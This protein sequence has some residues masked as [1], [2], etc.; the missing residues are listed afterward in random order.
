MTRF[1]AL[2]CSLALAAPI[3]AHH[4]VQSQFDIHK[5]VS[6]SGTVDKIEFINPHSYLT[7]NVKGADGKVQ[8]WAFEMG[9]AGNLRKAGVSRP[10]RGGRKNGEQ[11]NIPTL[12][13]SDGS[14]SGRSPTFKVSDGR[15]FKFSAD[16]AGNVEQTG[17]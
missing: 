8:K 16:A 10:D 3:W 9:A 1:I 14:N 2:L 7:V 17:R 12:P 5:T 15:I 13:A 4:S 6:V 11:G